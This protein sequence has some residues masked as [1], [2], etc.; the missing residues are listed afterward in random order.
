MQNFRS[1]LTT[2]LEPQGVIV[3]NDLTRNTLHLVVDGSSFPSLAD[4]ANALLK[5]GAS[6]QNPDHWFPVTASEAV[7][8]FGEADAEG[9][10]YLC[11]TLDDDEICFV[12]TTDA[13]IVYAD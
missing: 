13:T 11:V 9:D 6:R 1:F 5:A 3:A 4:I 12:V 8:H 7:E 2:A 10:Y